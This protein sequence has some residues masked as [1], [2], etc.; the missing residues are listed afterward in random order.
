MESRELSDQELKGFLSFLI[1]TFEFTEEQLAGIDRQIVMT[2][3]LYDSILD[4]C[5]EIGP[6]AN[7]LFFRMLDEYPELMTVR[8][9][10]IEE[11][12][13][14]A[15]LPDLLPEMAE[16]MKQNIY[17]EIRKRFGEDAI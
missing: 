8:A 9:D 2:Q 16:R 6:D 4:R 5:E 17:A 11:E 15:D 13:L 10:R 14:K 3:E 1:E 12:A 7:R